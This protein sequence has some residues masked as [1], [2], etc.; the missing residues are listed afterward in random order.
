[1]NIL[2]ILSYYN[3]FNSIEKISRSIKIFH[4]RRSIINYI[5]ENKS[6]IK[7]FE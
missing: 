6:E 5:K 1:M 3:P 4:K 2:R 7:G